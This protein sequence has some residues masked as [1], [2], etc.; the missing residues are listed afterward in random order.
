LARL[1]KGRIGWALEA[2]R[3]PQLMEDYTAE[4]GRM[5]SLLD[6]T[7][8]ERFAY[9]EEVAALFVRD[10]EKALERL[11]LAV[12]WWRDLLVLKNGTGEFVSNVPAMEALQSRAR[13]ISIPQVIEAIKRTQ[14][15]MSCLDGNI[16]PRL[17]LEVLM[18]SLPR[19]EERSR[20]RASS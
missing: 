16:N 3:N 4:L 7:L 12:S 6:D 13:W 8:E 11:K 1:S 17:A 9:A 20:Q 19:D 2:A 15:T 18:L 14:D 10:R 5:A